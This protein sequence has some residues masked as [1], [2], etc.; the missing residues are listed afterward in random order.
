VPKNI[1]REAELTRSKKELIS[2]G[3]AMDLLSEKRPLSEMKNDRKEI[4]LKLEQ[5]WR[6]EEIKETQ[7]AR[8]KDI[9]EGDKNT[10]CFSKANQRRRKKAISCLEDG[11]RVLTKSKDL[12]NLVVQYHKKLFGKEPRENMQLDDNFSTED[13]KVTKEENVDLEK[14]FSEEEVKK[15]LM[16]LILR[17]LLALMAFLLCFIRD[18]GIL[19]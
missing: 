14:E 12:I 7:R 15:V 16:S 5:I 13:E 17:G 8:E 1:K 19:R 11:E 10:A 3:D 9:K 2:E 6:I 18:C 4:S